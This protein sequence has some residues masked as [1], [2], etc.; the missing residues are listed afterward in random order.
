MTGDDGVIII[1]AFIVSN[2]NEVQVEYKALAM[3]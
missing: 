1:G 2:Q 3:Q